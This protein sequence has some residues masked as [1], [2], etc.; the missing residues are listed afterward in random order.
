MPSFPIAIFDYTC[1]LL[2]MQKLFLSALLT[3]VI[4][5]SLHAADPSLNL[6][7]R[8]EYDQE[9][10]GL[11]IPAHWLPDLKEDLYIGRASIQPSQSKLWS[12]GW[13]PALRLENVTFNGPLNDLGAMFAKL[14]R[15]A[16]TSITIEHLSTTD[17]QDSSIVLIAENGNW[18]QLTP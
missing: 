16:R 18:R 13:K 9:I 12:I 5:S 10:R 15:S 2:I 7:S 17:H 1:L 8:L 11:K 4:F 14:S 3:L 6:L